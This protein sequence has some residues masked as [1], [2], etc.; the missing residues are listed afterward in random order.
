MTTAE[1][2]GSRPQRPL[3]AHLRPAHFIPELRSKKKA[4]VLEEMVQALAAAG[5]TRHPEAVLDVVRR[6]EALGSTGLGKGVAVPHARCTLVTE[7]AVL[8][9]RS[10]RGV[11]FGAPDDA[12]VHLFFLI[13]APPA[14]RDPV[15]LKLLADL[16]RS[17]R[18]ARFRQRLLDAP[19]F[20]ALK[21]VF[22]QALDE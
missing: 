20:T 16:V 18:L 7:R 9:A 15:Y 19:D 4:A 13:V 2:A 3:E 14:E 6:R 21:A 17:V 1:I 12:P 11:D 22:R 8:V 5:V 10:A